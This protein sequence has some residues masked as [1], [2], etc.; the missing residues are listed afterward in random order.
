MKYTNKTLGGKF[1]FPF[2][3]KVVPLL[4]FRLYQ[5]VT[6]VKTNKLKSGLGNI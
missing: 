5:I 3:K 2:A 6:S 1:I 4:F